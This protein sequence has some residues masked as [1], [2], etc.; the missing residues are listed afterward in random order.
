MADPFLGEIRIFSFG[1]APQYWAKCEGQIMQIQQNNALYALLGT[2]FGGNGSTTFGLPD[3]RGRTGVSKA[4]IPSG[5][6]VGNSGGAATVTLTAVN[7]P[8]HNHAF[9]ASTQTASVNPASG[10]IYAAVSNT[11]YPIY[12]TP[13]SSAAITSLAPSTLSSNGGN[14]AHNNMQPY[15]ALNFCIA[16]AGIFPPRN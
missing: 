12:G 4:L 5:Y 2:R 7:L 9:Q 14:A 1:F 3:L 15:Q 6:A 10:A 16:T 11:A 8:P 13:T